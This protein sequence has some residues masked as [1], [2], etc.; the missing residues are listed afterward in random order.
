VPTDPHFVDDTADAE[1]ETE[2]EEVVQADS[3]QAVTE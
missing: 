2:T 3:G 1:P